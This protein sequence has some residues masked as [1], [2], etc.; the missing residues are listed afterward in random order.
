MAAK[1]SLTV[2]LSDELMRMVRDRVASGAYA[3]ESE[4]VRDGLRALQLRDAV[5]ERWIAD[6]VAPAFDRVAS[7]Q[8]P[9]IPASEVFGG[10]EARHRSNR[11]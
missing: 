8:E 7:G 2:T 5:V 11:G 4:V 10:L 1:Q 6:D 3:D 9:L